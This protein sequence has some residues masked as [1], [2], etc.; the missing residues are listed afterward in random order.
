VA[1]LLA[2]AHPARQ[3]RIG[4]RDKFGTSGVPE[5]LFRIYNLTAESVEERIRQV[6]GN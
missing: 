2:E 4:V 6:F 3:I 5:D 1:E